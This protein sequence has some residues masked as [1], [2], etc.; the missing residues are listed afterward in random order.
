MAAEVAHDTDGYIV[1]TLYKYTIHHEGPHGADQSPMY[2]CTR[3]RY[4]PSHFRGEEL[5]GNSVQLV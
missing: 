5:D 2:L 4:L 3:F 1:S